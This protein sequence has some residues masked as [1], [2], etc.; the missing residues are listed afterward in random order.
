MQSCTIAKSS[1]KLIKGKIFFFGEGKRTKCCLNVACVERFCGR[2][3]TVELEGSKANT[4]VS[5][6]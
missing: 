2:E 4:P 5:F 6:K 3:R 1:Q